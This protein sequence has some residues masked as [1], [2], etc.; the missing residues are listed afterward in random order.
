MDRTE[1]ASLLRDHMRRLSE[2]AYDVFVARI[3]EQRMATVSGESGAEYQIEVE[4]F[5][6]SEPGGFLRVLGSIDDGTLRAAFRPVCEDFLIGPDGLL[7]HPAPSP[8]QRPDAS[9]DE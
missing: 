2:F 5:W 6:D 8:S 9:V 3:G 4:V 7:G 1:A